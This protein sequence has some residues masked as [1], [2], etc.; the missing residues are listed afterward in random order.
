MD[1]PQDN[2]S[3]QLSTLL[4][5]SSTA[6]SREFGPVQM[7]PILGPPAHTR[8]GKYGSTSTIN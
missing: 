6:L 2:A 3:Q 4:K 5:N 7:C 1:L 8:Y